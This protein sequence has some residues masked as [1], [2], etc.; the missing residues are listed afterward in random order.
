MLLLLLLLPM[1]AIPTAAS[2]GRGSTY[3]SASVE[4]S[5]GCMK[6]GSFAAASLSLQQKQQQQQQQS[7]PRQTVLFEGQPIR[8]FYCLAQHCYTAWV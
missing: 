4:S 5:M 3:T 8:Y 6:R 7:A 1:A 2:L